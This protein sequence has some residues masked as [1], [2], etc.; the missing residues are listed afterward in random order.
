M[1]RSGIQETRRDSPYSATLHTGYYLSI[2]ACMQRSGIQGNQTRFP[3]FRYAA[4][5]LHTTITKNRFPPKS[6]R[7]RTSLRQR[8]ISQQRRRY[9][10]NMV[11]ILRFFRYFNRENRSDDATPRLLHNHA[12]YCYPLKGYAYSIR[13]K[14]NF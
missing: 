11:S 4:Y 14:R 9:S 6:A 5:G 10:F 8:I 13:G 12:D 3:V 1:Q 7:M 2:V